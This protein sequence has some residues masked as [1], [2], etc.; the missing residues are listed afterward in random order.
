[1]A[2][3]GRAVGLESAGVGDWIITSVSPLSMS[4]EQGG[5]LTV[6]LLVIRTEAEAIALRESIG[7]TP[8]LARR[9]LESV[10]L[11][12]EQGRRAK[13]LLVSIRRIRK[14]DFPALVMDDNVVDG[15][16]F[17]AVEVV[18]HHAGAPGARIDGD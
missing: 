5:K 1:M 15:V 17:A 7:H 9:R 16:E 2:G 10:D 13:R 14:P 6:H 18:D 8:D 12:G 4:L 11:T 3:S